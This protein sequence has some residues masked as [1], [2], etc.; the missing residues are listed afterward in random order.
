MNE[1]NKATLEIDDKALSES[2][3]KISYIIE[4]LAIYVEDLHQRERML[5]ETISAIDDKIEEMRNIYN[6]I[7]CR[8]IPA[9]KQ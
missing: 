2:L 6:E 7:G 9:I 8:Y 4:Y 3:R 5:R 1:L